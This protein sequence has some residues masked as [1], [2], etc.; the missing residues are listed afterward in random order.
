M[1]KLRTQSAK[2]NLLRRVRKQRLKYITVLPSL[3]TI[4]NGLCGFAAIV[5]ASNAMATT[6]SEEFSY[7]KLQLPY[8]AL[9]GYMVL[10]AMIAD[11]LDGRLARMSCLCELCRYPFGAV[12]CGK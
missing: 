1:P 4:L 12:Q 10:L 6:S 3:V 2:E 8:F 5:F 7:H 11:M 9:A